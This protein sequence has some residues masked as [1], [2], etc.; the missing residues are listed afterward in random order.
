[1][2]IPGNLNFSDS[3][4]CI[5][6]KT[7]VSIARLNLHHLAHKH[8]TGYKDLLLIPSTLAEM[9]DLILLRPLILL[10]GGSFYTYSIHKVVTLWITQQPN[11]RGRLVGF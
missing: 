11:R 6:L 10:H 5:Y 8:D 7:A 4:D 9:T 1:M 3:P 2:H